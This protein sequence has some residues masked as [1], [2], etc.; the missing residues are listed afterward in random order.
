MIELLNQNKKLLD[1]RYHPR[2]YQ[3][4][5]HVGRNAGQQIPHAHIHL[6]PVY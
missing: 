5:S 6:V 1:Q 3:I 2:G 4:F